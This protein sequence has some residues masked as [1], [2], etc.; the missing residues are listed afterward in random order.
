MSKMPSNR[1]PWLGHLAATS[2]L[3]LID[4][5]Q[6]LRR[7]VSRNFLRVGVGI[8]SS[9]LLA[10]VFSS[11][12]A[13][14]QITRSVQS[15]IGDSMVGLEAAVDMRAAVRETQ[16][17]LLRLRMASDRKLEPAEIEAF[18]G[19]MGTLLASY[20]N[21]VLEE[22]DQA[23][24][25]AIET[26]LAL[27]FSALGPLVGVSQPDTAHIQNADEAA[28]RLISAVETAY[29]FNRARIHDSADEVG[30]SARQALRIAN[31]LGWSFGIFIAGVLLIYFAYRA[32]ALPEES[33]V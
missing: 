1:F 4:L 3:A 27:Y 5:H 26:A 17:E 33:D 6:G 16:L 25:R 32:L 22:A 29:Q 28:R 12:L 10:I 18:R 8:L 20:H 30:N 11:L 13:L 24:A 15:L 19:N 9:I 31:R 7:R 14:I 21:G 2:M 23:N